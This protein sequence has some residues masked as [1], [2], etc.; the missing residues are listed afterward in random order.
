[1]KS[2][3][4]ARS[5]VEWQMPLKALNGEERERIVDMWLACRGPARCFTYVDPAANL[6]LWSEDFARGVWSKGASIQASGQSLVNTG[7]T[8]E[9]IV[10]RLDA[11]SWFQYCLSFLARG[12]SP[13][14]PSSVRVAANDELLEPFAVGSDWRRVTMTSSSA[15][16][17]EQVSFGLE[18]PAGATVEIA[19][20]QVEAQIGNSAYKKTTVRNGIY[21][22]ARFAANQLVVVEEGQDESSVTVRIVARE[23]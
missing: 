21:R 23:P 4:A 10:Q 19:E 6:L 12:Q 8:Q 14:P 7:Q 11:P 2:R 15:A 13:T 3:D 18:L 1:M 9:R 16:N 17:E 20:I 22:T 5:L